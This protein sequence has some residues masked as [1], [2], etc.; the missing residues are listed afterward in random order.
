MKYKQIIEDKQAVAGVIEALLLVALVAIVISII[1]LQYIPQIME[2]REAEHMDE[3]SNQFSYLKAMIDIQALTGSMGTDVPLAY[4]PMTSQITLGS[5]ELPYFITAPAYGGILVNSSG[6]S[7]ISTEPDPLFR[8]GQQKII[9]PLSMIKF[10]ADN[11]YFIDQTYVLE[12][13]GIILSQIDGASVMRADPCI[14]IK[15]LGYKIQVRMYL[16]NILGVTGKN[17]TY[18][19]GN[20][21]VRTNYSHYESFSGPVHNIIFKSE[22]LNAWNESLNNLFG[23]EI[24]NSDVK[25]NITGNV[26]KMTSLKPETKP[27]YLEITVVNIFCQIGPGWVI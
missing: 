17:A 10:N 9:F 26:V 14:S 3:V 11:S 2:Q 15:D 16:P 12:G 1:Q 19:N 21:F 13:G 23:E 8:E 6:L 5:R 24:H 20:C 4:V 18:G 25:V 22:Y 7:Y 27:F